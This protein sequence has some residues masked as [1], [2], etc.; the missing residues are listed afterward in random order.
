MQR[1]AAQRVR[2]LNFSA[3]P[4]KHDNALGAARRTRNVQQGVAAVIAE[5]DPGRRAHGSECLGGIAR[6]R[7]EDWGDEVGGGVAMM[8]TPKNI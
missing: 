7:G 3:Q 8:S 1:R 4:E 6:N 2:R 5:I